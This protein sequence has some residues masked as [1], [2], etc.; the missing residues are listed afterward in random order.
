M[1]NITAV[2]NLGKDPELKELPNSQ[3]ANFSLACGTSKGDTTWI[4]CQVW[5]KRANTVMK[6]MHK[7][8]RI[9]VAG[10]GKVRIYKRE[11][12]SEGKSLELNVS[13]FT[14]PPKTDKSGLDF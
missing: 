13:D 10:S 3:V 7:G 6:Y 14:L 12:G 11:D 8:D 5:G 9:T 2:G 1:L 4:D